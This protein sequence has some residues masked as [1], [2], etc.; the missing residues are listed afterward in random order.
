MEG[1]KRAVNKK[2]FTR[3]PYSELQLTLR[4]YPFQASAFRH[5]DSGFT[6]MLALDLSIN[7]EPMPFKT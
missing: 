5:T 7:A 4:S 6:C 3:V 2:L 1:G